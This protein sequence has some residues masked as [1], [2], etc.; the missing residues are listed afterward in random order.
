LLNTIHLSSTAI[1]NKFYD[2]TIS[3]HGELNIRYLEDKIRVMS[4]KDE[5]KDKT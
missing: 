4:L 3:K 5:V 2:S 1:I